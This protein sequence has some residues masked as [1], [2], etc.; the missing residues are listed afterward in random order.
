MTSVTTK[1]EPMTSP[2]FDSGPTTFQTVCQ[3]EAPASREASS[4]ARSIRLIELKMGTI[5]NIVYRCTK[6][7]TTEKSEN[8][9]H[10][11]GAGTAPDA[12][13][14]VLTRPLRPSSGTHEIMRI[15][16]DVQNGIV[17]SR[18]STVCHVSER[19]WK[20]RKYARV[21]PRTSVTSHT[22][23][24]NFSVDRYVLKVTQRPGSSARH[25]ANTDA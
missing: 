20:A 15:T 13:R 16:F 19:T 22:S 21:K 25:P 2:G 3:A 23:T 11:S 6:A 8:S 9:S 14:A 12:T 17:H 5:M 24:Q 7:R 10:S 18:N 1:I 4:S